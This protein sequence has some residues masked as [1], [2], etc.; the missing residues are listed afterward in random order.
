MGIQNTMIYPSSLNGNMY[1]DT[2]QRPAFA[3]IL[4]S[5]SMPLI[6]LSDRNPQLYRYNFCV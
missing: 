2:R 1:G 5:L 6:P 4:M 3:G